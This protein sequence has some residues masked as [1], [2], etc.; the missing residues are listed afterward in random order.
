M[1]NKIEGRRVASALV[2]VVAGV[3]APAAAFGYGVEVPE[4]GGVAFGRAGA[5][6]ARASDPSAIMLNPGGLGNLRGFQLTLSANMVQFSHCFQ[7]SGNYDSID[8][9]RNLTVSNTRFEGPGANGAA[10]GDAYYTYPN[11]IAYPEIC[12]EPA[13]GL[14]VQLLATYRIANRY[15]I[16]FGV[17][18]PSTQGSTQ[19]FPDT[20]TASG[21]I[22]GAA[23]NFL[24]PSPA[25]YLLYRKSLTVLYPTIAFG[26]RITDW[27][28]AGVAAH[29]GYAN[30]SF[31]LNANAN[32]LGPQSPTS[33]VFIGLGASGLFPAFTVGLLATPH[34]MISIGANFRYNAPVTASGT[35]NNRANLY[36]TS[37]IDSSFNVDELIA[38]LPWQLRAGVRFALPRAGRP[39][40]NDGSGQYDPMTDDLFDVEADFIYEATSTL[41]TTTLHNS[42]GIVT[43]LDGMGRPSMT[44]AAPRNISISSALSNVMGVRVGGDVN[45]LPGRLTARAG[46]SYESAAV[47]PDL[48]QIHLPAYA[49]VSVHGGLTFRYRWLDVTAGYAHFFYFGNDATSATRSI[50][51]PGD[52]A[53]PNPD[54]RTQLDPNATGVN[55]GNCASAGGCSDPARGAGT[56]TINRGTYSASQNSFNVAFGLRF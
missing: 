55:G 7:R 31:G 4:N 29:L 51:T 26:A 30:F 48:A 50:V 23:R 27:L 56:Y 18:S 34:R 39:T 11:R 20:V 13:V 45:I 54:Q 53:I 12:K 1:R 46:F 37:P 5:F 19:N 28:S 44:V 43:A 17:F 52:P 21:N 38:Q 15:T 2:G 33:D 35:A 40:Q 10:A 8:D 36:S 24:A 49:G 22:N 47:S 32:Y 14:A 16:G 6:V 9:A 42:G 3:L 41:S 25:R